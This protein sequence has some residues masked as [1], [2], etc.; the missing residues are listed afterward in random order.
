MKHTNELFLQCRKWLEDQIDAYNDKRNK[1]ILILSH[2]SP[3]TEGTS[4]PS[5]DGC[6]MNCCWGTD[7]TDVM[8]RSSNVVAWA[9]GHTHYNFDFIKAGTTTRLVSN[10]R[11]HIRKGD[12]GM[13][14]YETED[15]YNKGLVL[16]IPGHAG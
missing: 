8:Q 10:Q 3:S 2:F 6:E 1:P 15:Y 7:L 4:D 12:D 9:C 13:I 14:G 16:C 11:G 5:F